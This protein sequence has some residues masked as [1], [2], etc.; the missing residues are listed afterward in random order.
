[1]EI[2]YVITLGKDFVN[3]K[4]FDTFIIDLMIIFNLFLFHLEGI[5]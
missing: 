1:M 3:V 2:K 4:C 5:Q